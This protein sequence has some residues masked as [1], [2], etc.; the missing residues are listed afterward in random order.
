MPFNV[1]YSKHPAWVMKPQPRRGLL[2]QRWRRC[3]ELNP[4]CPAGTG[5]ADQRQIHPT[6]TV[7]S[8]HAEERDSS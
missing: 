5:F 1:S 4:G 3:R 2:T 6:T 8:N 7:L